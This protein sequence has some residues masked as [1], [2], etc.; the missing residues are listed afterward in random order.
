L[1]KIVICRYAAIGD[2]IITTPLYPLLKKDGW[3]ITVDT[4]ITGEQILR[5]NPYIDKITVFTDTDNIK[6]HLK[7]LEG[8]FDR[9]LNLSESIER[10]LAVVPWEEIYNAPKDEREAR[11]N[12]NYYD[13]TLKLAGYDITGRRGEMYFRPFENVMA[14]DFMKK[15]RRKFVIAW[16]LSGSSTHKAYPY[17]EIVARAFLNKHEDAVIITLGDTV[18]E[19]IEF[20]H[21]R[22]IN[23]AGRWN[24]RKSLIMT[25][26]VDLVIGPDTGLLHAAGCFTTPKI[27]LHSAA[28][29]T[30]LSKNWI[31]CTDLQ[32]GVEC[33]PC[34]RLLF[35]T[36][37]CEKDKEFD[38]SICMSYLRPERVWNA[39]ESEYEKWR[40][41]GNPV[42][43]E[44]VVSC[45]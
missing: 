10:T 29:P 15:F 8:K 36:D 7:E 25:K 33:Q 20:D 35:D 22:S 19:L 34:Y 26:F 24:I 11:C 2:L 13:H 41:H 12:V 1:K 21:P 42:C 28:S 27:L 44:Q 3:H 9:V 4:S 37:I 32:S 45:G 30:N 16:A 39:L 43:R 5:H 23:K 17:A 40:T 14:R 18:T 6:E 38:Q 31:N